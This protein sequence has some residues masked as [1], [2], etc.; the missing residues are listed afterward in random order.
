MHHR[1]LCSKVVDFQLQDNTTKSLTKK[2]YREHM[3][4]DNDPIKDEE[5]HE[6]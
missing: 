4:A 5:N 2:Y 3:K 6:E 1:Y